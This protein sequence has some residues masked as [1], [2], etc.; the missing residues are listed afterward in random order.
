M[1]DKLPV[2]TITF[3]VSIVLIVI[4]YAT[5]DIDIQQAF[6]FLG[7]SGVAAGGIG[8]ARN[9]AGRGVRGDV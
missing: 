4:A 3:L 7:L 9:G 2:A 5:D 6:E 1:L 8:W